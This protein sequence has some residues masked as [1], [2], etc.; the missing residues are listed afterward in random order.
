MAS[1][2]VG[3]V[4]MLPVVGDV[5]TLVSLPLQATGATLLMLA[6]V[7]VLVERKSQQR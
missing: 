5:A 1:W 2:V 7:R 4:S 3:L 6:L